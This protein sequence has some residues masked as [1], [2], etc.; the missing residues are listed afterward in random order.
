MTRTPQAKAR[1][2]GTAFETALLAK[3]RSFG[4]NAERLRLSGKRDEGDIAAFDPADPQTIWVIEA[5]AEKSMNLAGY[6][7]EAEVERENY[8][9]K[10][11]ILPDDV[12]PVVV[13]KRRN[14]PIEKAYVVTTVEQFFG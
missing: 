14:Q 7:R 13:V 1:A 12:M 8:A 4:L 5:K 10:R 11:G 2:A 6:I 9:A 3:L